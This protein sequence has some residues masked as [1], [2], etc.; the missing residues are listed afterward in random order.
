MPRRKFSP[1]F[2][3]SAV[4]LVNEQGYS[5]VDAAKSLGINPANMRRWV[6]KFSEK[7]GHHVEFPMGDGSPGPEES[8]SDAESE[9]PLQYKVSATTEPLDVDANNDIPVICIQNNNKYANFTMM[10]FGT[11]VA[12][13]KLEAIR[14]LSFSPLIATAG[15][16]IANALNIRTN[17]RGKFT[18]AFDGLCLSRFNGT[19]TVRPLPSYCII[20]FRTLLHKNAFSCHSNLL[21][22]KGNVTPIWGHIQAQNRKMLCLSKTKV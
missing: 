22:R 1:E 19:C 9:P 3:L 11:S 18:S 17:T 12:K 10:Y 2:K 16:G 20:A 21:I 6:G 4:K 15:F 13:Y 7:P 14:W 5:I 8:P